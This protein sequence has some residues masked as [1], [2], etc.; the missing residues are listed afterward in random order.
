[1]STSRNLSSSVSVADGTGPTEMSKPKPPRQ[2]VCARSTADSA[3]ARQK[4]TQKSKS[5]QILPTNTRFTADKSSHVEGSTP[6]TFVKNT[7]H[8][9]AERAQYSSGM[10]ASAAAASLRD[11]AR[12]K[13]TKC[14]TDGVL[15]EKNKRQSF[16]TESMRSNTVDKKKCE[17]A[18]DQAENERKTSSTKNHASSIFSGAQT[19]EHRPLRQVNIKNDAPVPPPSKKTAAEIQRDAQVRAISDSTENDRRML[20]TKQRGSTV[21]SSESS[22][23]SKGGKLCSKTSNNN[24]FAGGAWADDAKKPTPAPRPSAQ[25]PSVCG[26]YDN[27]M[28]RGRRDAALRGSGGLW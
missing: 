16:M 25:P 21:F 27:S 18:H 2:S 3:A 14:A 17:N 28:A 22:V 23:E 8:S 10:E 1:M 13:A 26:G 11:Q 24:I 4:A 20:Q 12:A 5:S 9:E 19:I 6:R 15:F 7:G